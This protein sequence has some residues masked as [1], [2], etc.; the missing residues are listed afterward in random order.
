MLSTHSG[1]ALEVLPSLPEAGEAEH[2]SVPQ[3]PE[4]RHGGEIGGAVGIET[5]DHG[6]WRSEIE[7]LGRDRD[8]VIRGIHAQQLAPAHARIVSK[9]S[10]AAARGGFESC[11]SRP[12]SEPSATS[13]GAR[14]QT[15][16]I[17]EADVPREDSSGRDITSTTACF[18]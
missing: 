15:V 13:P 11:G 4:A 5:A 6:N 16:K 17:D 10:V 9:R 2:Q 3:R 12:V 7:N 14:E 18:G 8:E 1:G